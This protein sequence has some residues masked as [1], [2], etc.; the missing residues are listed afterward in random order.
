MTQNEEDKLLCAATRG[1]PAALSEL[2]AI[3][4]PPLAA[5]VAT[6]IA[7]KW[8]SALDADD[9]MQV[10]Y[11]EAFLHIRDFVPRGPGAFEAWL[12][13]IADNNLRDAVRDLSRAK[14]PQPERRVQTGSRDESAAVLLENLGVTLTTPSRHAGRPEACTALQ[15]A[16]DRLPADYAQVVALY[17]LQALPAAEVAAR[18]E[19]SEGAV[20]MLRSRALDRL[21]ET[22]GVGTVFGNSA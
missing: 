8:R 11:F 15:A 16:I 2:L 10:T 3:C 14:R 19:R 21:R 1:D 5:R 17:D 9:V 6:R 7:A 20:Y 22:L 13:R 18:M 12:R 4:G